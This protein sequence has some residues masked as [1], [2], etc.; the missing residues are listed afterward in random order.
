MYFAINKPQ[1]EKL[2]PFGPTVGE[3]V[4]DPRNLT[5]H[6]L[7]YD[8]DYPHYE[9]SD[10]VD[11]AHEVPEMEALMRQAMILHNQYPWDPDRQRVEAGWR[12]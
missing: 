5:C 10:I 6:L 11:Y 12:I 7:T 3:I 8:P 4:S 1:E 2:V 9:Y